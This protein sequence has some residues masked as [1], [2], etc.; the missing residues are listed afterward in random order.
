MSYDSKLKECMN[1]IEL[2]M[3]EYGAGGW[4]SLSSENGGEFRFIFPEWSGLAEELD[5]SGKVSGVRLKVKKA[6]REKAE[7]TAH[8]IHSNRDVSAQAFRMFDHLCELTQEKWKTEHTPFHN[9]RP[10]RKDEN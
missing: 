4:V 8:F 10:H 1:K 2:I 3:K 9:F 6:E 7:L 5:C